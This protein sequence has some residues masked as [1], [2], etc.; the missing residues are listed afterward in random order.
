MCLVA[1][2]VLELGVA[3]QVVVATDDQ[4]VV[5]AVA[6]LG[7]EGI[8]TDAELRSGTERVAAVAGMPGFARFDAVLNVQG[9]EPF[10][11][12]EAAEGAIERVLR[13]DRIGTAAAPLAKEHVANVNRVKVVVDGNGHA[14]RFSRRLPASGAWACEVEVR[15]HVGIYAYERRALLRWAALPEVAEERADG[16]EQVRPLAHGIPI[17]VARIDT[18]APP[19]VDTEEDLVAAERYADTMSQRAGR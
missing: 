16:L 12:V 9:D 11:Q 8:V 2:R 1:R 3:Q 10:F 13:G 18:P 15:H 19:S 5:E 14:L 7:V 6:P 4:R 17:G